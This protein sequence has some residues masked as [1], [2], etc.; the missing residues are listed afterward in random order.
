MYGLSCTGT[1]V[2]ALVYGLSPVVMCVRRAGGQSTG[3]SAGAAG[4]GWS[5]REELLHRGH[6]LGSIRVDALDAS[7]LPVANLETWEFWVH[8]E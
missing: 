5:F 8:L 3:P 1:C 4:G 7:P 2:R 6:M